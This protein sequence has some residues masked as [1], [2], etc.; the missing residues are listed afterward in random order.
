MKIGL[1]TKH[2]LAAPLP[3]DAIESIVK[4][5]LN[6]QHVY[7]NNVTITLW[8]YVTHI[9]SSPLYKY[10]AWHEE[11]LI[12]FYCTSA[13]LYIVFIYWNHFPMQR[14]YTSSHIHSKWTLNLV[15]KVILNSDRIPIL[16]CFVKHYTRIKVY[17]WS[18]VGF[19]SW[20]Y[21]AHC[22]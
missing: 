15:L 11:A 22:W 17:I 13:V 21:T 5:S 1:L 6:E 8:V 20:G 12:F 9:Q 10:T 18:H 14:I 7:S 19:W 4:H 2:N 3:Y 16:E